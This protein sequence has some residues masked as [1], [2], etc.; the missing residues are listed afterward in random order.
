[1]TGHAAG[2]RPE[3]LHQGYP[4]VE[5]D[6]TVVGVLTRGDVIRWSTGAPDREARIGDAVD[7]PVVGHPGELVGCLADRMAADDVGRAP[8][9]DGDGK[10]VGLVSRRD[11]LRARSK[12]AAEEIE[13]E[14]V[15][16]PK[17]SGGSLP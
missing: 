2:S 11:L 1:M 12:K 10:L 13:R 5:E 7:P 17:R 16:G 8:I 14:R 15:F 3:T 6:G 4:V 9:V